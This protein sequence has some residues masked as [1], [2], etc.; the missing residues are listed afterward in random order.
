MFYSF[1]LFYYFTLQLNVLKITSFF[2]LKK[3]KNEKNIGSA[4]SAVCNLQFSNTRGIARPKY[5]QRVMYNGYKR[6]HSIKFQSVVT[7]NGLIANLAGPFE[8]KRHDSTMLHESGLLTDLRR[9]GVYNG[10]PL[11]LYGDP[12]YPLGVH[13]QA[14]FRGNNIT[15]QMAIYNKA[16]SEVRI[17]VEMLFGNIS[18]YFKFIDF[19][20]QMKVNLSSVGKMYVVC[21]LLEDAQTCLYGN[22][23]SEMF[24]IDPPL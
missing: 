9:V 11:C 14:P 22:Q 17:A 4:G 10:D 12:A 20:R 21:A 5:N 3:K 13:L 23:V 2:F 24:G 15:P 18:N 16:M 7:P 6:V 1:F 19:K 8:G